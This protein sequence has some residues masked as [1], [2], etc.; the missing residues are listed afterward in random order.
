MNSSGASADG[1]R[2]TKHT[3]IIEMIGP[4]QFEILCILF[5]EFAYKWTLPIIQLSNT[6]KY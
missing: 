6:Y 3:I 5:K 1:R 2:Q 4:Y